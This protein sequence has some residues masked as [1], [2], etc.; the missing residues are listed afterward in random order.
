MLAKWDRRRAARRL[1]AATHSPRSSARASTSSRWGRAIEP[2]THRRH[3]AGVRSKNRTA[4]RPT[5]PTRGSTSDTGLALC[6]NQEACAEACGDVPARRLR[7]A[8]CDRDVEG[9][10]TSRSGAGSR[11]DGA[12]TRLL[13][14]DRSRRAPPGAAACLRPRLAIT[15]GSTIQ[16]PRGSPELA[17]PSTARSRT[18]TASTSTRSRE[19]QP[20]GDLAQ[21]GRWTNTIASVTRTTP[22][23]RRCRCVRAA[24]GTESFVLPTRTQERF[25]IYDAIING[26]RARI[27]RR[28]HQQVLER[29]DERSG[30]NWTFWNTVLGS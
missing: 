9:S 16:A 4:R 29:S 12:P 1:R 20:N 19:R 15:S 24:A 3:V 25:M 27:L 11:L 14:C 2:W 7:R 30:W 13:P 22:S 10:K 6:E 8:R 28:Q 18:Y 5:A 17:G 23:G 26:A 21:V